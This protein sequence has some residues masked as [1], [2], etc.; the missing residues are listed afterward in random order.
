MVPVTDELRCTLEF[1]ADETRETPGH[2]TGVLVVY[3][4]RAQNK[5]RDYSARGAL[6]WPDAGIILNR[7]H[8]RG[9][10]IA[11]I[12]P[13]LVGDE[14]RID[15]ALPDTTAGRDAATEVRNGTLSRAEHRVRC[16][17]GVSPQR[18]ASDRAG[19]TARGRA[20]RFSRLRQPR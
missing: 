6:E 19:R 15:M 17:P 8:N 16:A 13:E 4:K 7:Q 11:R 1:R 20:G 9:Q 12:M 18:A 5:T 2:L 10:P 3:E 14:V